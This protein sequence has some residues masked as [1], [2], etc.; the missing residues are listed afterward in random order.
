MVKVRD[1]KEQ[2]SLE[3]AT[4]GDSVD[5]A[6][7][8]ATGGTQTDGS[9]ARSEAPPDWLGIAK[10]AY[11]DSTEFLD[12]SLRLQWERNERAFQSRHPQR[13]KYFSDD[14]RHRSKIFRPKTRAMIRAGEAAIAQAYF[15][16]EEVIAV[17]A[18]DPRNPMQVASADF[19]KQVLQYRLTTP[20]KRIGVP[21]FMTL[22]AAYQDAQKYGVVASKQ[23]WQYRQREKN[24]RIPEGTD[25]EGNEVYVDG[26]EREIVFDR[27][28][29][30]LIA[31]ENLRVDRGAAW[32]DPI[33]SSPYCIVLHPMYLE[34]VELRMRSNDPKTGQPVWNELSRPKLQQASTRHSWDST[35]SFREGEQRD[36]S[37]ESEIGIEEYRIVW[38]HENFVRWGGD[39][40]VYYTA[41]V[42]HMLSD[43]KPLEE[44]YP[45]CRDGQRPIV[46]GYALLEAH[47]NYPIGKP[48]L[49]QNLQMEANEVA[50]LTLDNWKLAINKR[51][52]VARGKQVDLRSLI[53][54]SSSSITLVS[55][56]EKDVKE[57]ETRDVTGSSFQVAS[58]IDLDIDDVGGNFSPGTVQGNRSFNETVGGMTMLSGAATQVS[59]L[60][61]RVFTETWSEPVVRQL[62]DM[63]QYYET[64]V[65][66][67]ALAGQQAQLIERYG[68]SRIDDAFLEQQ[69][70]LKI[71]VGIGAADPERQLNKFVTG[72]KVM[73]ELFGDMA[74]E[75]MVGQE[76][77]KEIWGNLGYRDGSR[78]VKMDF[79]PAVEALKQQL[80]ELNQKLER[81]ELDNQTKLEVGRMQA[82]SRILTQVVESM[83]SL[84]E[85]KQEAHFQQLQQV[86]DLI[87]QTAQEQ[88][89]QQ[90][91]RETRQED[92]AQQ[93]NLERMKGMFQLANTKESAKNRPAAGSNAKR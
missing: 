58:R 39:E 93:F 9:Q 8:P 14:Y 77:S 50:N 65:T 59:D 38:V 48:E 25:E 42:H 52:L 74:A 4:S 57:I 47:K 24:I 33:N 21:W 31:P 49:V 73:K 69:L 92:Y 83:G 85:S 30:S 11:M 23:W 5:R 63:E 62:L 51:Y 2:A 16:N 91:E 44:V 64:D 20:T 79:D 53:R 12:S 70:T 15:K 82:L 7:A 13:S 40:W 71:N 76:V 80:A 41:G 89:R 88:T 6:M 54:N 66:I 10:D 84:E 29:V 43:P 78:F 19:W 72:A 36:D 22:V 81:K 26:V 3:D 46:M 68:I 61:M 67:M 32:D 60:D 56:T 37:K 87:A 18:M 17:G 55:D 27:P 86:T 90:G 1:M 34:D 28:R 75:M 45:H 35:R